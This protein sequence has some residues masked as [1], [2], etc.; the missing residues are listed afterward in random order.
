MKPCGVGAWDPRSDQPLP[1]RGAERQALAYG[2]PGEIA[3]HGLALARTLPLLPFAWARSQRLGFLASPSPRQL[4]GLA[5]SAQSASVGFLA[6]RI[7]ESGA[8]HCLLRVPV[9]QRRRLDRA[10]SLVES[11][12]TIDW[13]IAVIQDRNSLLDPQRWR[14][15]LQRIIA[16]FRPY[17]AWYQIGQAP[18]RRK[19]GCAHSGEY[20]ALYRAAEDLRRADPGLRLV[21]PGILDFDPLSQLRLVG[22][23]ARPRFDA[24]GLG[25]YVDR[26]GGP[27]GRQFGFFDLKRK[28]RSCAAIAA[29]SA[30]SARRLW[31]TECNW[32]L[33]VPGNW[34]PAGPNYQVD[35]NRYAQHMVDYL[36]IAAASGLVERVYWW[37]PV[38]RGYGLIDDR[39]LRPRPAWSALC[40]LLRHDRF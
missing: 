39:D 28:I 31:I 30:H 13:C 19:W 10:I 27:E 4:I 34:A 25:L 6:Q 22:S 7:A 8:G 29:C 35:E 20:L 1:L 3:A 2:L 18:N 33:Q 9:W 40:E 5:L 14:D 15:D 11:L 17:C 38:A 32:P 24:H 36:R 37:Q 21:G 12:P 16:R 26:R 23:P